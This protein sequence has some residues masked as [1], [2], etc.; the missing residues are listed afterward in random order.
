[1]KVVECKNCP[2]CKRFSIG[3]G[4]WFYG[5][6]HFPFQGRRMA[7]IIKCP[8]DESESKLKEGVQK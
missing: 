4:R 2:Y 7:D 5:C 8:I 6:V 3:D 1:M